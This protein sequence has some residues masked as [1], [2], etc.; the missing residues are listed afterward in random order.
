MNVNEALWRDLYPSAFGCRDCDPDDPCVDCRAESEQD[1]DDPTYLWLA[2]WAGHGH[3]HDRGDCNRC[4]QEVEWKEDH[5]ACDCLIW[6]W[7]RIDT[8]P[9]ALPTPVWVCG[10]CLKVQGPAWVGAS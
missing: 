3:P 7:H 2:H 4:Q 6:P 1:R 10:S 8:G 9:P 5:Y